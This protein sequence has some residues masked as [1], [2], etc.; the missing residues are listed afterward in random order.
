MFS[1]SKVVFSSIRFA[2][3]WNQT[4]GGIW[5]NILIFSF[6]TNFAVWR[7]AQHVKAISIVCTLS[8]QWT[9]VGGFQDDSGRNI[10]EFHLDYSKRED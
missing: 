7:V 10:R 6:R 8:E 2:W 9:A 4:V 1:Y 3:S 5:N